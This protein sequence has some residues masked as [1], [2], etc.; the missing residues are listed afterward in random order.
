MLVITNMKD[1][2][3][4]QQEIVRASIKLISQGGIQQF[5]TKK[6][7]ASL[8]ISEPALYRHFKNKMDILI[9]ILT[10]IREGNSSFLIEASK[11]N[12]SLKTIEKMF[13]VLTEQLAADPDLTAIIFSEEIFQN[14]K[15]LA[16]IVN[17]MMTERFELISKIL[18]QEQQAGNI[19]ND[20]DSEQ[21]ATMIIG[22]F[23]LAITRWKLSGFSFD[24]KEENEKIREA[25]EVLLR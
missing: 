18:R 5:T 11:G 8:G 4:R 15:E 6:L 19:R 22:S 7:A 16:E 2:T 13:A 12:P 1:L 3:T 23:R 24:L 20:I 17:S 10:M 9:T 21:L 14:K 25:V